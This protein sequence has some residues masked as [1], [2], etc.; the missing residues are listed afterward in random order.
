M[1]QKKWTASQQRRSMPFGWSDKKVRK[2][3]TVA[4]GRAEPSWSAR[5]KSTFVAG[6][7]RPYRRRRADCL[8]GTD[9][10]GRGWAGRLQ[11]TFW[12]HSS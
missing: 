6:K 8:E 7:I 12:K 2:K 5:R 3:A 10:G 11:A 4:S 9:K 1:R